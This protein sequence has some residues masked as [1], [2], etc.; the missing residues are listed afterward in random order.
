[1]KR[2][3]CPEEF[4]KFGIRTWKGSLKNQAVFFIVIN[5]DLSHIFEYG[6]RNMQMERL[7]PIHL[8]D[9]MRDI[10]MLPMLEEIRVRIGQPLFVYTAD[11]EFV[12]MSEGIRKNNDKELLGV[13][14]R[15]TEQ[16]ILE[17]QNYISNYSLYAWQEELRNGF[18]TIQGGHRIGL[19]GGTT[20][21]AGHISGISY[22]TFFNIRVAHERIGCA[23]EVL[24]FMC[25]RPRGTHDSSDGKGATVIY[26]T[27]IISPP[28]AGK[29]TMLRDCIRSISYDGVKVGLV[30]ERSEI[31]ASYHGIPQNDVG[32]RTDVL[33]GCNKPEGIQM[34][35]R[36]MSPQVI[37][38]DELGTEADFMAVEQAAYSG[39]KVIGTVHAGSVRELQEKPVLKKWYEKELF[40]RFVFIE[41]GADGMRKLKVYN[42]RWE[43]LCSS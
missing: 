6:R 15:I 21:Q 20:N 34:L 32:P 18:V 13:T 25:E 24:G 40:E 31:A 23:N 26:N 19:A 41:K 39:C 10:E 33:D 27:L 12:L 30:D 4:V 2:I 9:K 14:Y 1:M 38:V 42:N 5:M 7:F 29:T 8:R 22:L 16:D 11:S 35:L 3:V 43:L 36:T 28:G 37:A 17:M